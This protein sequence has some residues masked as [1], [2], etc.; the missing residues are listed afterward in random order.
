VD[1]LVDYLLANLQLDF[2]GD[3]SAERIR[4]YL[5]DDDGREARKV[6]ARLLD[7][8]NVEELLITLADC[9]KDHIQNGIRPQQVRDQLN[10]FSDS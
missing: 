6:L 4:Q 7:D 3:V 2:S 9:L 10:L 1:E 8:D 5:R